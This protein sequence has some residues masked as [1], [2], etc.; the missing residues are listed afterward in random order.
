MAQTMLTTV[1]NPF[2]PFSQFEEWFAFDVQ[3]GYNSCSYL[4]RIAITSPE[5][6][7]VEEEESI[8]RAID[9]IVRLNVFGVYVKVTKE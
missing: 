1:D 4:A 7:E 6:S 2:N 3:Q 9:E 5:L 8:E